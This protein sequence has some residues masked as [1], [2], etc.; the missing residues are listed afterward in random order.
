M[1]IPEASR[2][3]LEVVGLPRRRGWLMRYHHRLVSVSRVEGRPQLVIIG[4]ID[5][6]DIPVCVDEGERGRAERGHVVLLELGR[7]LFVNSSAQK[8]ASC[9]TVY[10]QYRSGQ[11][12]A[13]EARRRIRTLEPRAFRPRSRTHWSD[14]TLLMS[15]NDDVI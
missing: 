14:M 7:R 3:F 10:D 2:R 15:V 11:W 1:Q 8:F 9:L 6:V 5:G 13:Q 4:E 12:S